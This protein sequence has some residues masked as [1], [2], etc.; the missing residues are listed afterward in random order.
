MP[1]PMVAALARSV[2]HRG[3]YTALILPEGLQVDDNRTCSLH[4]CTIPTQ[5]FHWFTASRHGGYEHIIL[6]E[7]DAYC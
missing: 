5:S 6:E 7:G 2:A 1:E 4:R 3:E